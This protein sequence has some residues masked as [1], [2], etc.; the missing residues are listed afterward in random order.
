M[1]DRTKMG[2]T[3]IPSSDY[4]PNTP[5]HPPS[6]YAD[7]LLANRAVRTVENQMA[8][9]PSITDWMPNNPRQPEGKTNPRGGDGGVIRPW[10]DKGKA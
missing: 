6:G 10:R 3:G 1:P 4:D 5:H 8:G 9:I 2:Q 7:A